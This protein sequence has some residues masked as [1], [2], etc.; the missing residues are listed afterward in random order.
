MYYENHVPSIARFKIITE[1]EYSD[2][3]RAIELANNRRVGA[4]IPRLVGMIFSNLGIL[5]KA[6]KVCCHSYY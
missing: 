2:F 6:L 1:S 3:D 4:D 5:T